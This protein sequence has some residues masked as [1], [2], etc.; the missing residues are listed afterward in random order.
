MKKAVLISCFDW[1]EKRLKPIR[2]IFCKYGYMV[3][4]LTSDFSHIE[5]S[6]I[7]KRLTECEYIHVK[8]YHKNLSLKRVA[9]HQD[10]AKKVYGRL[11]EIQPD[12]I[13]VLLPPNMV[14]AACARYK[15]RHPAVKLVVDIIDLWPESIPLYFFRYTPFYL[16]WKQLRKKAIKKADRIITECSLYQKIIES[17]LKSTKVTTLYLYKAIEDT[18]DLGIEKYK[19]IE[20]TL[21]LAYLGSINNIVDLESIEEIVTVAVDRKLHVEVHVIGEGSS[22]RELLHMLECRGCEVM[23]YGKLF[24]ER[25]KK[26]IISA[27]DFAINLMKQAVQVGLTIKSID[28]LAYGVPLINNLKGDTR[29]LIEKYKIGINY[30]GDAHMLLDIIMTSDIV[31]LHENAYACYQKYFTEEIFKDKVEKL[32][33]SL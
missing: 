22:R 6:K 7:Q 5:K 17:K 1:Y 28:Y 18:T 20:G 26:Q 12:I 25:R 2:E 32:V 13:Y 14:A 30:T 3:H 21:R 31:K 9:S 16:F 24:D 33:K 27:C 15:T 23:Y 29:K 11:T 8:A 10:F 19:P 4:I